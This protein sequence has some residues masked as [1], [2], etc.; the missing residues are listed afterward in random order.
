M[1]V[2]PFNMDEK[3]KSVPDGILPVTFC[4]NV[5]V[6][7]FPGPFNTVLKTVVPAGILACPVTT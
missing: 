6:L 2:F 1:E 4:D 3:F 5:T 7:T